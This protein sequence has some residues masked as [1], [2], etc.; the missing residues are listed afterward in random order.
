MFKQVIALRN[1]LNLSKSEILR[2]IA[3]TSFES[4][5][6]AQT[7][8]PKKFSNW[9]NFGQKKIVI[10]I[11]D[12][13]ELINLKTNIER[14]KK[15]VVVPFIIQKSDLNEKNKANI[16]ALGIGPDEE[17]NLREFTNLYKLY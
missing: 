5:K 8:S 14:K 15:T 2:I 11:K 4:A 7:K 16:V 3:W 12:E 17:K 6:K 1:D 9:L 10:K 13:T